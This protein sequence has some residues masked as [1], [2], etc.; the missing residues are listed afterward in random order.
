[1]ICCFSHGRDWPCGQCF[2]CRKNKQRKWL[3]R[4]LCEAACHPEHLPLFIT[5]T[6]KDPPLCLDEDG[7]P[8]L[9]LRPDDLKDFLKRLRWHVGKTSHGRISASQG[10]PTVRYYACGEYGT[11]TLRPH[12]HAILFGLTEQIF[13]LLEK[14][15]SHGFVTARPGDAVNM[16]YTLKYVLKAL[17]GAPPA[18]GQIPPFARMSLKPPLG[19]GF[20]K[21]IAK[22]LMPLMARDLSPAIQDF[23][24]RLPPVM[25]LDGQT[26]PLD[27][28]MKKAVIIAL[29]DEGMPEHLVDLVYPAMEYEYDEEKVEKSFS[30]HEKALRHRKKTPLHAV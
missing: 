1:M 28:T 18:T 4:L 30:A 20:A 14:T 23:L 26:L 7:T 17:G 2:P 16:A 12:Y 10:K 3:L 13:P 22:S 5:L 27:R 9:T 15:W 21:N 25:R 6:Y 19:T 11:K 29:L 8:I 24:G